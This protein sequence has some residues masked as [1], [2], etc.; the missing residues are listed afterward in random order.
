MGLASRLHLLRRWSYWFLWLEMVVD[1]SIHEA[2]VEGNV[3][4][5]AEQS[6][7]NAD[8]YGLDLFPA[9]GGDRSNVFKD[10]H[11]VGHVSL[12]AAATLAVIG[13]AATVR[14]LPVTRH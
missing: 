7:R 1:P 8:Q 9:V 11:G 12:E 14:E 4:R 10:E 13:R 2:G 6:Q 3:E 5:C